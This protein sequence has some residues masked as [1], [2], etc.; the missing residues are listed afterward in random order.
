MS[1]ETSFQSPEQGEEA[2]DG[3]GQI[4]NIQHN[5]LCKVSACVHAHIRERGWPIWWEDL[6]YF[7]CK[8]WNFQLGYRKG[9]PQVWLTG[10]WGMLCQ[11]RTQNRNKT[12]VCPLFGHKGGKLPAF[13]LYSF[14]ALSEPQ[15]EWAWVPAQNPSASEDLLNLHMQAEKSKRTGKSGSSV[16]SLLCP[17]LSY[18]VCYC[19]VYFLNYFKMFNFI[20]EYSAFT[21]LC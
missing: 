5:H 9:E 7:E 16:R 8:D 11:L 3:V 4:E 1:P 19:F 13:S 15:S 12:T 14:V 6:Q 21:L 10:V 17:L 2:E 18:I 20:L